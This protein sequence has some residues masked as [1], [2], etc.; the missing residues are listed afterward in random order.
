MD[1]QIVL[2]SL[3]EAKSYLLQIPENESRKTV[4]IP[5]E[6]VS[7]GGRKLFAPSR[8]RNRPYEKMK[9]GVCYIKASR[10]AIKC[11][12]LEGKTLL[13]LK[14]EIHAV[15]FPSCTEEEKQIYRSGSEEE[16]ACLQKKMEEKFK[17]YELKRAIVIQKAFRGLMEKILI[18]Y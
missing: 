1:R 2:K 8:D 4:L 7:D 10:Q 9:H 11:Y 17:D 5:S 16:I 13:R 6:W 15:H 3:E 12:I 14:K 18:G